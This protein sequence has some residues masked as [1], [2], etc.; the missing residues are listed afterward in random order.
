MTIDGEAILEQTEPTDSTIP[1]VDVSGSLNFRVTLT[2]VASICYLMQNSLGLTEVFSLGHLGTKEL[3]AS[4]LATMWANVSG[5]SI[6]IG[7]A[8]ALDTLCSQSYTGS[9]DP[10]I[11]GKH[12]QRSLVIMAFLCIPISAL[13]CFTEPLL[14]IVGQDPEIARLAG[15]YT[16]WLIP[17]LFPYFAYD[18][19]K[20]YLQCQGIMSGML[21]V[22]FAAAPMNMFIQWLLVWGWLKMGFIGAPVGLLFTYCSLPCFLYLYIYFFTSGDSWG[23]WDLQEAFDIRQLREFLRLGIPG[24]FQLCSEWWAFEI[25]ALAAGWIG[26]KELAAQSIVLSSCGLAYMIP[27]GIA[28]ASTTKI[29]NALGANF[30]NLAKVNA[31]SAIL[32]GT[33]FSIFNS[34]VFL[35]T[36][37]IWGWLWSQDPE[38]VKIVGSIMPMAA[39]FQF[40]DG[41]NCVG[42]GILRGCGQQKVGAFLNLFGFYVVGIPIGL[43]AA[44]KLEWGLFG[45][46]FGLGFALI[47]VSVF[48]IIWVF[49]INWNE[50]AEKA[51]IMIGEETRLLSPPSYGSITDDATL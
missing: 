23:G 46:W 47:M 49:R 15:I 36:G 39:V 20:R 27:L 6:G 22:I 48:E 4:A 34:A 24:I 28:I 7:M 13:W 50:E 44:F 41:F 14:V 42:G 45:L 1:K 17:A 10:H 11:T 18:C 5:F 12:L 21:Y 26:E 35:V 33:T 9:S 8:S 38:V 37:N 32:L 29:G 31:L 2:Q 25:V 16:S 30:P 40:S 19:M 43:Y 3:A 51:Q